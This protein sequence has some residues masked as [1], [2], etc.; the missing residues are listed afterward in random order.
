MA[1]ISVSLPEP[2]EAFI[3][4]QVAHGG[5]ASGEEYI[6]E[7]IAAA[8]REAALDRLEEL[9]REGLATEASEMTPA[10]WKE[11][12]EELERRFGA[13]AG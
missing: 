13:T 3:N 9:I 1:T 4:E 12:H 7:L 10:D 2:L 6:R 5:H 11:L 8:R